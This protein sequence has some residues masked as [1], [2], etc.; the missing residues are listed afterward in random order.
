LFPTTSV[1]HNIIY[2]FF[3]LRRDNP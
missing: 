3:G 2:L 1:R